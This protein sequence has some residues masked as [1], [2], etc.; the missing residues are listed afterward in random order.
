METLGADTATVMD[1]AT[2]MGTTTVTSMVGIWALVTTTR[3]TTTGDTTRDT[4]TEG[5]L[6]TSGVMEDTVTVTATDTEAGDIVMDPDTDTD[7]DPDPDTDMA[8][9][10][11]TVGTRKSLLSTRQSTTRLRSEE[12]LG[13]H[14][15]SKLAPAENSLL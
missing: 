12:D 6:R 2:D 7:T 15:K 9:V 13:D 1:T 14:L 10:T 5:G 11:G 8:M 4:A 3:G